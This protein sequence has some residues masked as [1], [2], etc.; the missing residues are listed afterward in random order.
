MLTCVKNACVLAQDAVK[1]DIGNYELAAAYRKAGNDLMV[2]ACV[3]KARALFSSNDE[4]D[5]S[6]HS[7][8]AQTSDHSSDEESQQV[9]EQIKESEQKKKKQK[10][11]KKS[12]S[13]CY[14]DPLSK[15][16]AK[17]LSRAFGKKLKPDMQK[18]SSIFPFIERVVKIYL[19]EWKKKGRSE[20]HLLRVELTQKAVEVVQKHQ[21][22]PLGSGP[23]GGDHERAVKTL[24]PVI[25][26][27]FLMPPGRA[28]TGSAVSHVCVLAL[29]C[30]EYLRGLF[31][32]TCVVLL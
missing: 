2:K 6:Y 27:T 24:L 7:S 25:E 1:Q 23:F 4:S 31:V 12:W 5:S 29:F 14:A 10:Q 9:S 16:L 18:T 13:R 28:E 11:K 32:R 8:D 3:P 15:L 21:V 19:R 26:E 30:C 17:S 20:L 22:R